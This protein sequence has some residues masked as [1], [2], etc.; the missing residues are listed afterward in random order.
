MDSHVS[1]AYDFYVSLRVP[2]DWELRYTLT[3]QSEHGSSCLL[4]HLLKKVNGPLVL[5]CPDTTFVSDIFAR[6]DF[7]LITCLKANKSSI[8]YL[9]YKAYPWVR[10]SATGSD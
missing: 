10:K 5:P 4:Q 3:P 7:T 1:Y 9:E 6:I 2:S 8:V